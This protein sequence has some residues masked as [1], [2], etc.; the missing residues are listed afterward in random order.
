MYHWCVDLK[1]VDKLLWTMGSH[2]HS[3]VWDYGVSH[4][5]SLVCTH[6][7]VDGIIIGASC[8][9]HVVDNMKYCEEGPLD[10]REYTDTFL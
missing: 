7:I 2:L 5:H 6:D 1:W 4:L 8:I 3:L 10:D 9:E